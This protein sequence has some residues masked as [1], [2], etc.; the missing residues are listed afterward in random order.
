MRPLST[1]R[2]MP[3]TAWTRTALITTW[4]QAAERLYGYAP[5]E[6][7]G[8]KVDML[9]PTRGPGFGRSFGKLCRAKQSQRE[10][11]QITKSGKRI[12]VAISAATFA[13]ADVPGRDRDHRAGYQ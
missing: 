3:S 13:D 9:F 8:R 1:H 6:V 7:I 11:V 10:T 2:R 12:D 5:E 4:N